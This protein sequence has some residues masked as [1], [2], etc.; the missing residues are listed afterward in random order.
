MFKELDKRVDFA[1][2]LHLTPNERDLLERGQFAENSPSS[3]SQTA[4]FINL[5]PLFINIEV[6][7]R[8]T[9]GDPMIQLAAWIAAEFN[10]RKVEGYS[11][12]MP[13]F[14]IA[15][16]GDLWELYIA[17]SESPLAANDYRLNFLGPFDMGNTKTYQGIFQILAV[18][19]CLGRWGLGKYR[20][21][22]EKEILHKYRPV[23]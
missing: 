8:H 15:I 10:K 6:K 17:Y 7:R 14:A 20:Q 1:I 9:D 22:V 5:T 13:V 21:W 23:S 3:I 16:D 2:G 11:L 12:E 4:D 19:C 18:L